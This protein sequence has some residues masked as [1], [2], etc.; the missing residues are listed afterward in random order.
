MFSNVEDPIVGSPK[1]LDIQS[2]EGDPENRNQSPVEHTR[3]NLHSLNY[4]G[5]KC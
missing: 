5:T 3:E 4:F 1:N 2:K